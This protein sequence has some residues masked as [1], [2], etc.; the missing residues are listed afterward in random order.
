MDASHLLYKHS[1][2]SLHLSRSYIKEGREGERNLT[3]TAAASSNHKQMIRRR[4]QKKKKKKEKL[5]AIRSSVGSAPID[6]FVRPTMSLL[7]NDL[8]HWRIMNFSSL[9]SSPFLLY[10]LFFDIPQLIIARSR[11]SSICAKTGVY[12]IHRRPRSLYSKLMVCGLA[13]C[14]LSLLFSVESEAVETFCLIN[15]I[16]HHAL[17]GTWHSFSIESL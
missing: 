8:L 5:I 1:I 10:K 9:S 12:F 15:K 3:E 4:H 14:L 16:K 13:K 2:Y 11:E 17:I 7:I 6:F